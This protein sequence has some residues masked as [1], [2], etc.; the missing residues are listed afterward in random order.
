MDQKSEHQV[1]LSPSFR[2]EMWQ[3]LNE[4]SRSELEAVLREKGPSVD[5]KET[6]RLQELIKARFA[7]DGIMDAEDL[8]QLIVGTVAEEFWC[9]V[10]N[11]I[12]EK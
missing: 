1:I 8:Y 6:V 11:S 4:N 3:W 9:E 12:P 7:K 2:K 5:N 10:W